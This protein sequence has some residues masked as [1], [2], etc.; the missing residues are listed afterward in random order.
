HETVVGPVPSAVIEQ[1]PL[2][3]AT[4]QLPLLLQWRAHPTPVQ[5]MLHEPGPV[6]EHVPSRG[7][8]VVWVVLTSG[9][10]DVSGGAEV[11]ALAPVSVATTDVSTVEIVSTV[12]IESRSEVSPEVSPDASPDVS[13]SAS[14]D[15]SMDASMD[16]SAKL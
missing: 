3:H 6:H 4:S 2:G 1:P 16:A 7:E 14:A 11:S 15:T 13:R 12:D 10:P 8:H 9:P 5:S